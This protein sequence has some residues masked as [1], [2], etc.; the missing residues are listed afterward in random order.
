MD[1]SD[2]YRCGICGGIGRHDEM[3]HRLFWGTSKITFSPSIQRVYWSAISDPMNWS[4]AGVVV[5]E[6]DDLIGM[7]DYRHG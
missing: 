6:I 1:N 5:A 4:D 3:A 7:E 2:N